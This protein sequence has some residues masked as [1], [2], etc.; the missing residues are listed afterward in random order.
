[1]DGQQGGLSFENFGE[2]R[3]LAVFD[4]GFVGEEFGGEERDG[5]GI[6]FDVS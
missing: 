2:F 4:S 5:L 3:E 6:E 1:L